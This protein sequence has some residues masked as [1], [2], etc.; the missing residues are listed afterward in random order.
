MKILLSFFV[1][2][3]LQGFAVAG[4]EP[5]GRYQLVAGTIQITGRGTSLDQPVL[6]R[7]DTKTGRT[8]LYLTPW[9]KMENS[10]RVGLRFLIHPF[11]GNEAR[12]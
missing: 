2:V 5:T 10:S 12:A 3:S 7:I 11:S 8:W 1:L 6:V 4:D 9:V